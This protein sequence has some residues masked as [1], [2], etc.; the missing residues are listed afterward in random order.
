M[1]ITKWVKITGYGQHLAIGLLLIQFVVGMYVNL[2]GGSGMTNAH[3][4]VGGLLLLDGLASVVFA[5]LSKRTPLVITTIIGL[6]MLLFSFYA[7]S[8][9]VQNGKNVFSFDMSI[10]YALSL[11]A[12]IFGA[13]FVN[14]AR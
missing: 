3:M 10:G 2:Y 6:L 13:L 8:E 14:R 12:Y 5:I 4:M 1:S 7:G 11:A 9:F